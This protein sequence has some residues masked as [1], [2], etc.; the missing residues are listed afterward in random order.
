MKQPYDTFPVF[1][2]F[3]FLFLKYYLLLFVLSSALSRQLFFICSLPLLKVLFFS[4]CVR[5]CVPACVRACV[6]VC[7]CPE[8]NEYE[9]GIPSVD[10]IRFSSP[11]RTQ[12]HAHTCARTHTHT[13]THT[14]AHMHAHTHTHTH[15][16]TQTHTHTTDHAQS[17]R[18]KEGY[19]RRKCTVENACQK[20]F[21]YNKLRLMV[22]HFKITT[23]YL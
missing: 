2:F 3:W 9:F 19:E 22:Q 18:E 16:H 4:L 14:R 7:V 6:C 11:T 8:V 20:T 17:M 12:T 5:A 23:S 15:I 13:N 10:S 1:V 21:V